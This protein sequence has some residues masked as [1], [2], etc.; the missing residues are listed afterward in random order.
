M[1][2]KLQSGRSKI[3][4]KIGVLKF[5]TNFTGKHLCWSLFLIKLQEPKTPILAILV[6]LPLEWN[7]YLP[8]NSDIVNFVWKTDEEGREHCFDNFCSLAVP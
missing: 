3:F 1:R 8:P 4:F 7:T 6:Y 5:F 2:K